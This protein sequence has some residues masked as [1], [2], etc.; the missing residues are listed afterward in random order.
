MQPASC[1]LAKNIK[2]R[3][4]CRFVVVIL[5]VCEIRCLAL[6]GKAQVKSAM[7]KTEKYEDVKGKEELINQ[8]NLEL[9]SSHYSTNIIKIITP[10]RI[11]LAGRVAYIGKITNAYTLWFGKPAETNRRK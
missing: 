4:C 8:H 6:R 11:L 10:R 2:V 9:C 3:I 1:L 5:Y 7:S